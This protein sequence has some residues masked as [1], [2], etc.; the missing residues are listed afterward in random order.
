MFIHVVAISVGSFLEPVDF[1]ALMHGDVA[2]QQGVEHRSFKNSLLL[3]GRFSHHK[4]T[5]G[6]TSL[7]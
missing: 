6:T 1:P 2:F 5:G 3:C 4:S 7:S